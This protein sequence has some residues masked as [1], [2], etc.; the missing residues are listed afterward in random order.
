MFLHFLQTKEHKEAFLELAYVVAQ[1]DGFINKKEHSILR[2]YRCEMEMEQSEQEFQSNRK[3]ADIIGGLKDEQVKSIF[4]A[5][6]LLLIF[7]DGD[8][9][10]DEKAITN[11]LKQLFGFSDDTFESFKE[12]VIRMDRLKIEGVKLILD[13]TAV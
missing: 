7:A 11:E 9:N 2:T 6:I 8:Y 12:W 4:L 3:L 5:E 10:D 1:A 13:P